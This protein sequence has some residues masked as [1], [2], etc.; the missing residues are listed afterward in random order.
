[1][2]QLKGCSRL[3]PR[4]GVVIRGMSYIDVN[5]VL[6][7][8][9]M[10]TKK[11]FAEDYE[12]GEAVR[13]GLAHYRT[14]EIGRQFIVY[15]YKNLDLLGCLLSF[16]L[17]NNMDGYGKGD[18]N[19]S[20]LIYPKYRH[21]QFSRYSS[22]NFRHMMFRSGVA[23]KIYVYAPSSRS[24]SHSFLDAMDVSKMPCAS[25]LPFEFIDIRF[26]EHISVSK[27]L[28]LEGVPF[29]ILEFDGEKYRKLTLDDFAESVPNKGKEL[30]AQW[31]SEADHASELVRGEVK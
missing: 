28:H 1:M 6:L 27:R 8:D 12:Y 21:T 5:D 7:E 20:Q 18:F 19:H 17:L 14:M 10:A 4:G 24:K 29:L 25:G 22:L 23:N 9:R 15:V 2:F 16:E 3:I 11:F 26:S 31:L 13:R 30:V